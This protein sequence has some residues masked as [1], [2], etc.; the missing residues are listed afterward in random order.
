MPDL[1]SFPLPLHSEQR[2]GLA[3]DILQANAVLRGLSFRFHVLVVR[4]TIPERNRNNYNA[5]P[6]HVCLCLPLYGCTLFACLCKLNQTQLERH[7][8]F[9]SR[10]LPEELPP[11]NSERLGARL[12]TLVPPCA[13]TNTQTFRGVLFMFFWKA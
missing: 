11:W 13:V 8:Y 12:W 4:V 3:L 10:I 9:S 2:A 1:Q 6:F 7:Q 5:R